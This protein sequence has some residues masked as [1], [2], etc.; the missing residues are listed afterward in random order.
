[1]K[2][3]K[4]YFLM[5]AIDRATRREV[6]MLYSYCRIDAQNKIT[7]MWDKIKAQRVPDFF[8]SFFHEEIP[9]PGPIMR[10]MAERV[11]KNVEM[12]QVAPGP[13]RYSNTP[14]AREIMERMVCGDATKNVIVK[15]GAAIG[16]TSALILGCG[17]IVYGS[18]DGPDKE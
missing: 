14:Y 12:A 17:Y 4:R 1:M 16:A 9:E 11:D 8:R 5:Q 10:Q 15:K 3:N 13:Y 6:R 2:R 7:N 18:A